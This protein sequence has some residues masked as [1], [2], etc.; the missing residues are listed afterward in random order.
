MIAAMQTASAF[1]QRLLGS[2]APVV[3]AVSVEYRVD[4]LAQAALFL[5]TAAAVTGTVLT[6]DG[7]QHLVP[8]ARDVMFTVR[9]SI[10]GYVTSTGEN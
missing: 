9:E 3:E 6:V 4:D 5:A 8:S 7:G 10:G 2:A 1:L